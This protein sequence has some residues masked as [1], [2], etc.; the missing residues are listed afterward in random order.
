MGVNLR[1]GN[2]G[3]GRASSAP[4]EGRRR[5]QSN[6]SQRNGAEYEAKSSWRFRLL[7]RIAD[8]HPKHLARH[9]LAVAGQ[10]TNNPI[11]VPS[12]EADAIAKDNRPMHPTPP[13]RP[14]PAA[15]GRPCRR[16]AGRWRP[17]SNWKIPSRLIQKRAVRRRKAISSIARSARLSAIENSGAASSDSTSAD[18]SDSVSGCGIFAAGIFAAGFRAIIFSPTAIA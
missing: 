8:N 15:R 11:G 7:R 5:F 16:L 18:D 9:R 4:R 1:G 10:K 3:M 17:V 2:A 6:A 13:R 14:A 12:P